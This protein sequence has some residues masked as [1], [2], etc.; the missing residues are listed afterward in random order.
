MV[1]SNWDTPTHP[2]S[3]VDPRW[4]HKS[5][6]DALS[7]SFQNVATGLPT[8]TKS[9]QASPP[10]HSHHNQSTSDQISPTPYTSSSESSRT[11][12]A[13]HLPQ[14]LRQPRVHNAMNSDDRAPAVQ[15]APEANHSVQIQEGNLISH[16]GLLGIVT[17]KGSSTSEDVWE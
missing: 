11:S 16:A 3:H 1:Y 9:Y 8:S 7:D 14:N 2:H 15:T 6:A 12:F 5:D 17:L 10:P 13:G 4:L